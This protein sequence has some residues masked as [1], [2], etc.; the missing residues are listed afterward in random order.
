M[1]LTLV[2]FKDDF[3]NNLTACLGCENIILFTDLWYNVYCCKGCS[4]R[5]E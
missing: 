5:V 2:E 4:T 1:N 3:E